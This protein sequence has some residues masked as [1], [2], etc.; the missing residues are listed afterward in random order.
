MKRIAY[1]LAAAMLL[2]LPSCRFIRISDELK[3]KFEDLDIDLDIDI[4]DDGV[5]VN[6]KKAITAS[7]NYIT[8]NDMTGEFHSIQCN[9]P[10]D[11]IYTPGD[12]AIS[13]EGP[14]NVLQHIKVNNDNGTLTVKT[15]GVVIR[16][17]KKFTIRLSSPVLEDL[18][19]NG[20][21]DFDAPEGI[22]ALDFRLTVNGAGD[23]NI[24]GLKADKAAITVN[25]AG[26]VDVEKLDCEHISVAVNGAGDANVAGR[27]GSAT[28]NISG[29]GDIDA[30]K[31][32]CASIESKVHGIGSIRK[33]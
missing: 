10:G 17:L 27:A 11:V 22:T 18:D 29:A 13:L 6:E 2:T 9:V 16:K 25:G 26:D 15:D 19:F 31:L 14:D 12:C 33:P 20:A 5:K 8:R 23:I 30:S 28:L 3:A 4:N 1:I 32:Q 24:E 21:V 7:S